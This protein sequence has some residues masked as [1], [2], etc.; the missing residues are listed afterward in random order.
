M[1]ERTVIVLHETPL[2]SWVRDAS[3]V[4]MFITL[5]GIG[6]FLESNAMQWVGAILGFL[7]IIGKAANLSNKMTVSEARAHLAALDART[8][9]D[10]GEPNNG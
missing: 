7:V 8:S 5:I 4:V 10:K 6:V 1:K 2:Q 9:Q 3:S